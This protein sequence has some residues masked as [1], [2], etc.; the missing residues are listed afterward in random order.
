MKKV[1]F[2]I[3]DIFYGSFSYGTNYYL[4]NSG[5]DGNSG[6]LP[7]LPWQ[8]IAKLNTIPLQPGDSVFFECGSIFRGEVIVNSSGNNIARI[9]FGK[10]GSGNLPVISG[11]EQAN[12]WSI[13][14]G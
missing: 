1:L 14:T 2:I 7:S 4:S 8:T 12:S 5:S 11:A 13:Y 3:L 10:Y 6:T 9:Y